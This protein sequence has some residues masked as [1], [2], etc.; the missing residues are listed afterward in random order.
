MT[1]DRIALV[2]GSFARISPR[3]DEF[4]QRFYARLFELD[5]ASR[6]LFRSDLQLQSRKLLDM[7]A[8]IVD[9]LQRPEL[10]QPMFRALGERHAAYGVSEEQYDDVGAALLMS[11][12]AVLGDEFSDDVEAAW[13]TLYAELA[14]GHDRCRARGLRARLSRTD[15]ATPSRKKEPAGSLRRVRVQRDRRDDRFDQNLTS[16]RAYTNLPPGRS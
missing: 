13:A 1:P 15:A 16:A 7:L 5:P 11:L 10:L 9:S 8:A 12:R 4:G 3:A 2:C 14:R 6:S